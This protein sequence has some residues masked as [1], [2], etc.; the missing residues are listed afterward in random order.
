MLFNSY[1]FVFLFLPSLLFL[2]WLLQR[3]GRQRL[4]APL[5]LLASLLFYAWWSVPYLLLLAGSIVVNFFL[6][7]RL[8]SRSPGGAGWLWLGVA[9]NLGLLGYFKYSN[10]FIHQLNTVAGLGLDN[11]PILLPLAISFFTFQQIAFLVDCRRG[12]AVRGG[13]TH[14]ALF[15]S[16][17]PQ[18]IAGPIVRSTEL[19]PQLAVAGQRLRNWSECLAPALTLFI[20]GLAKKV[21]LADNLARYASPV[22][23]AA[24]GGV[25]ITSAEAWIG[26]L[27]YTLQLYFDFSGYSDMAIA[28]AWMFGIRLPVNFL[29]PYRATSITG[30]W[31]RWH[32]TLSRFLREYLYIPL[33]GNRRGRGRQLVNLMLTM[34]LGGLWHGAGWNFV[35]WGGLHGLLLVLHRLW[36][37]LRGRFW[38]RAGSAGLP[39]RSLGWALTFI[40]VMSAWVLFRAETLDGAGAMLGA[41]YGV[42][43]FTLPADYLSMLPS[44]AGPLA[45]LGVSAGGDQVLW[46][47][48][49]LE[50]VLTL[51]VGL[52]I[53]LAMP[54][55]ARLFDLVAAG[56][57]RPD[58]GAVVHP[59]SLR[60]QPRPAW[61][62]VALVMFGAC[63][64]SMTRVSEFLYFQF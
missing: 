43:G 16:F 21:L 11:P 34:L 36:V 8:Q 18:L 40:A 15:V 57:S 63:L 9:F 53:A 58:P 51:S 52:V 26:T 30:F 59:S 37:A 38:R 61:A 41:M 6:G 47:L 23:A 25:A 27:A 13:F 60:W 17:F 54:N 49:K 46:A 4:L 28:L 55:T 10:F 44:L 3:A 35:L 7:R 1:S 31:R 24:D 22:F 42:G 20:L 12:I 32:I 48:S 45:A 62:L 2:A 5:L 33:G 64:V 56:E 50:M 39:A 14:Y 19:M 29:S